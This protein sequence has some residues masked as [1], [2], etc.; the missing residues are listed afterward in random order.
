M[1]TT[2]AI[3]DDVLTAAK[4]I[5][6]QINSTIGEVVPDLARGSLRQPAALGERNGIPLLPVRTQGVI[7]TSD[8]VNVLSDE[9]A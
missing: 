1:R 5:A 6:Q 3:E 9:L 8:I 2:L 7:V 4:G